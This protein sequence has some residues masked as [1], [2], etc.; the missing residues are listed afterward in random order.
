MKLTPEGLVEY[1]NS[2]FQ[3]KAFLVANRMRLFDAL[4][5]KP[6]TAEELAKTLNLDSRATLIV[7]RA[8][9]SLGILD[10]NAQGC[11]SV[12]PE[13]REAVF[14]SSP[15]NV[16]LML[17]NIDNVWEAMGKLEE[18][19]KSGKAP[20][21]TAH[22]TVSPQAHESFIRAMHNTAMKNAPIIANHFD[23]KKAKT[24]LDLGGGPGSYSATLCEKNPQLEATICDI[25]GTLEVSK[26]IIAESFNALKDRVHHVPC[27][28]FK[29]EIPGTYDAVFFSHIEHSYSLAENA[30]LLRKILAALKPGGTMWMH[31]FIPA[32]DGITPPFPSIFAVR[33]LVTTQNGGCYTSE[34][35]MELCRSVGFVDVKWKDLGQP[36]GLS[37]I[38]GRKKEG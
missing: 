38:E 22:Y 5:K 35:L 13:A 14:S 11:F 6:A 32:K 7:L 10:L 20:L 31:D 15:F 37:I 24:L 25:P 19:L 1:A 28:F 30:G 21:P 27:D 4:E 34:E 3:M 36:R 2:A 12:K 9:A 33:M 26:K 8:V 23:L 29:D 17:D 16:A 18:T